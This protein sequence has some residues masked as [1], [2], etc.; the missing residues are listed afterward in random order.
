M[1]LEIS[2]LIFTRGTRRLGNGTRV[3]SSASHVANA[4]GVQKTVLETSHLHTRYSAFQETVL[5]SF[6][7]QSLYLMYSVFRKWYWRHLICTLCTRC[8]GVI[9]YG[10]YVANVLGVREIVLG[11]SHLD[12]RY[13]VFRNWYYGHLIWTLCR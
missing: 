5:E 7:P 13:S 10:H 12:T 2:H 6:H 1:V 11:T 3:I 9:S 4:L 8:S